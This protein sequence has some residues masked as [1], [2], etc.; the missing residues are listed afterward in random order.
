LADVAFARADRF[1][2]AGRGRDQAL[3]QIVPTWREAPKPRAVPSENDCTQLVPEVGQFAD[4]VRSHPD[5]MVRHPGRH[6]R[7]PQRLGHGTPLGVA[8]ILERSSQ[9][10]ARSRELVGRQPVQLHHR[11]DVHHSRVSPADYLGNSIAT[12]TD[13]AGSRPPRR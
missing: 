9:P 1:V 12:A 8:G 5:E 10:I 7:L 11:I 3:N 4:L 13:V 2:R 6:R